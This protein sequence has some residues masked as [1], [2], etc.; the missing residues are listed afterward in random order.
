[1]S[2][3]TAEIAASPELQWVITHDW[4]PATYYRDY[5]NIKQCRPPKSFRLQG[6]AE[7]FARKALCQVLLAQPGVFEAHHQPAAQPEPL[8]FLYEVQRLVRLVQV[9][10]GDKHFSLAPAWLAS[11][12]H[13]SIDMTTQYG[14]LLEV[15]NTEVPLD[16]RLDWLA[17]AL[18]DSLSYALDPVTM[19]FD[20][21]M[22]CE[23]LYAHSVRDALCQP[24]VLI[25]C[26]MVL[27]ETN[28]QRE[29]QETMLLQALGSREHYGSTP[30]QLLQALCPDVLPQWSIISELGLNMQQ[31]RALLA[32]PSSVPAPALPEQLGYC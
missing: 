13:P 28:L 27:A 11:F 12:N 32:K 7:D 14:T 2:D 16:T 31:A 30:Q 26:A 21:E 15:A 17:H 3:P 6:L 9:T 24:L 4:N 19:R 23:Y 22:Q 5:R 25:W 1:M 8:R 10:V 20:V 18:D 29:C